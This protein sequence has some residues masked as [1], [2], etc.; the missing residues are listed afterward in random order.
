MTQNVILPG[1]GATIA[2]DQ[3]TGDASLGTA[4]V[5]YMKIMDG[6]VGGT[7]KA[8]VTPNGLKVD[9]SLGV[10][11]PG[12]T[13]PL[14]GSA[15][16]TGATRDVGVAA[17]SVQPYAYFNGFFFADQAGVATMEC[18]NTGAFSGEQVVC[19]TAPLAAS[20]PLILTVPVMFRYHRTKLVNGAAAEAVLVVN[21]SYTAA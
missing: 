8:G 15:T 18:S 11:F 17:G 21:A 16:Y 6:A 13:T 9:G 1:T 20:T 14:A 12:T 5:Q 10:F 4:D 19:A 2:A 3:I 7:A